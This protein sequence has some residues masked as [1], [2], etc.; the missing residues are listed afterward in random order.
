[1]ST[2]ILRTR[3][4]SVSSAWR[5]TLPVPP[6]S[7]YTSATLPRMKWTPSSATRL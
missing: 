2:G 5:T 4:S 3:P 7:G 1:M 6:P